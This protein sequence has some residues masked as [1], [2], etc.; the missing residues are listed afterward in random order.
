[1]TFTEEQFENLEVSTYIL[2]IRDK[3]VEITDAITHSNVDNIYII[4]ALMR[5]LSEKDRKLVYS[6][7]Y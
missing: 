5:S 4:R 7:K 6:F 3:E 1:M 2:N